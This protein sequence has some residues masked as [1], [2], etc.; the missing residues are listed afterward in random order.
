MVPD[1]LQYLLDD[2]WNFKNLVKILTR[3]PPNYDQNAL[4]IQETIWEHLGNI[5]FVNLGINNFDCFD[6][7]GCPVYTFFV[8]ENVSTLLFMK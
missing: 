1:R 2:F 7:V 6:C 4:K 8:F 3:G 5:I